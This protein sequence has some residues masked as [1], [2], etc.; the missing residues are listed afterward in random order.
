MSVPAL[1]THQLSVSLGGAPVLRGLSLSLRAGAWTAVVGPNGAGKSTL[2]QALAGLLDR[3]G[4]VEL[5]GR[6]LLAYSARERAR[7]LAWLGQG[8]PAADDLTASRQFNLVV[9]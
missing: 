3:T 6:P 1:Q 7:Q 8:Q 2:L 4:E 5:L 9:N